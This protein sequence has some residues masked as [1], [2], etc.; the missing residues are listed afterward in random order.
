MLFDT[1]NMQLVC[2]QTHPTR[3]RVRLLS[4]HRVDM[5]QPFVCNCG[6]KDCLQLINGASPYGGNAFQIPVDGFRS[7]HN[8][9]KTVVVTHSFRHGP[10][11]SFLFR[12]SAEPALCGCFAPYLKSTTATLTITTIFSQSIAGVYQGF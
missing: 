1:S 6:S 10:V 3:R 7:N 4:E 12:C 9:G 5:A 8:S 2:L 11:H